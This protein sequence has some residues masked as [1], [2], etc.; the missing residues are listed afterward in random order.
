M[1][2]QAL[3]QLVDQHPFFNVFRY[4]TFRTFLSFLTSFLVCWLVGPKFIRELTK[5]QIGQSVR[6]D[7]PESHKKKQGTPTMGGGLILLSILVTAVFWFDTSNPIVLACLL[8]TLLFGLVGYVDDYMKVSK[9]NTKGLSGKLR[10]GIEFLISGG[11]IALLIYSSHLQTTLFFPFF[12]TWSVDLGWWY[13]PFAS[14]V[15]V[16][17]ANAVNLTDGLD[18]LAIAP[19]I[20]ASGTLSVLAYVAGHSHI[21][22]YLQIPFVPGSGE[23]T[24][25]G[26]AFM[27]AGL[28]FLW[29]NTYPAQVFMG[30]IGSLSLGGFLGAMAVL[31]KNEILMVVIG[32][33]FVVE[34]LSV[35]TQV[36]SFKLTGKRVFK[37]APIHH[38]F[39]LKGMQEPK[40]IVRFWIVSIILAIL[41]L[42]T[43]KLR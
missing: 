20:V 21:A 36:A 28:G 37:M 41:S 30:D 13:V 15:I 26:A 29:F 23:L 22:N 7:G 25:I 31:T 38:H 18:G 1:F 40:V 4:I 27:A 17:T 19:V 8:I 14:L 42:S 39:E 9:K 32:G 2:Y 6:S 5:K 12:K 11:A 33:V 43:L 35:I 16:G 10:L 34:A 3:H 24:P